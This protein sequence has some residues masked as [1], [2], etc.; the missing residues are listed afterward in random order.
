G[1]VGAH[2]LLARPDDT[3]A[4]APF[5]TVAV[6]VEPLEEDTSALE[7]LTRAREAQQ[8]QKEDRRGGVRRRT[9]GSAATRARSTETDG[10]LEGSRVSPSGSETP[11]EEGVPE[12]IRLYMPEG[13]RYVRDLRTD[14]RTTRV[15]EVLDGDLDEF[16]LA[17]LK[18]EEA[19]IAWSRT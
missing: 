19:G 3:D 6:R 18:T 16:I 13:D 8:E 12:V 1:E 17:Y 11:E 15:R 2:K 4:L 7:W 9:P 14:V 5:Q 10:V